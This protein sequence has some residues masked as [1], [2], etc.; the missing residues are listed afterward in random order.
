MDLEFPSTEAIPVTQ[1]RALFLAQPYLS[2]RFKS[3]KIAGRTLM[4]AHGLC[5]L[6]FG[7]GAGVPVWSRASVTSFSWPCGGGC[8][9]VAGGQSFLGLPPGHPHFIVP[10]GAS[11]CPGRGRTRG[12]GAR[13]LL[14]QLLIS[15][16]DLDHFFVSLFDILRVLVWM[17]AQGQLAVRLLDIFQGCRGMELQDFVRVRHN[18]A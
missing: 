12:W 5:P 3:S 14:C 8:A 2:Y 11:R 1:R 16:V 6:G 15:C 13:E 17:V 18:G 10:A 4:L 7:R 9:L